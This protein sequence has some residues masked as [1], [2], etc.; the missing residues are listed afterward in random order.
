[1][2][3]AYILVAVVFEERDLLELLGDDYRRWRARTPK[4]V[5]RIGGSAEA[6]V[7]AHGARPAREVH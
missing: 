5:P 6:R 7:D 4:F 3:S 1:M 2:A